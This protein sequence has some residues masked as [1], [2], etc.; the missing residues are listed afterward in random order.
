MEPHWR[1]FAVPEYSNSH[2]TAQETNMFRTFSDLVRRGALDDTW[3]ELSLK[4]QRILNA[5]HASALADGAPVELS[6]Y[7]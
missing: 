4:T 7:L 5:C 3:P 1:R 2:P 6:V